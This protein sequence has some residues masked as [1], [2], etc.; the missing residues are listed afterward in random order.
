MKSLILVLLILIGT[1]GLLYTRVDLGMSWDDISQALESRLA[2]MAF[3]AVAIF[4]G[5]VAA[6]WILRRE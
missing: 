1:A 6:S 2:S 3:L 5:A 4:G